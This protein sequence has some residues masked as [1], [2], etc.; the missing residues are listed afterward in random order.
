MGETLRGDVWDLNCS[1]W[2]GGVQPLPSGAI[3][4][5]QDPL[6][7]P[8]RRGEQDLALLQ[9]PTLSCQPPRKPSS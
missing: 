8:G 3:A 4:K 2:C 7:V 1:R 6:E 5:G 9:I